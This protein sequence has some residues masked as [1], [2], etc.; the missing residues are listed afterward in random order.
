MARRKVQIKEGQQTVS[1]GSAKQPTLWRARR[2]VPEEEYEEL[3]DEAINRIFNHLRKEHWENFKGVATENQ[4]YSML[5]KV[6]TNP[7]DYPL[8]NVSK[9]DSDRVFKL[10]VREVGWVERDR[11]IVEER[12]DYYRSL[13]EE[14]ELGELRRIHGIKIYWA[15]VRKFATKAKISM[16]KARD[17]WRARE[18]QRRYWRRSS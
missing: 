16:T 9:N 6:S 14:G 7:Q 2:A 15:K 5:A 1:G 18:E 4:F 17:M 12:R 13:I 8:Q 10:Y 3:N 11:A